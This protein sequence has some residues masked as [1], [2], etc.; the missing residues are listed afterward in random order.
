MQLLRLRRVAEAAL[1]R[2]SLPA[3][4]LRFVT[5]GENTTFRLD[6]GQ[7]RFLV[8]VHRP[9]RHGRDVHAETAIASEMAWLKA[10]RAETDL[11]VPTA[12]VASDGRVVV[13]AEAGGE[14]RLV[15]VLGWLSGRIHED[16]SRPTHFRRLGAALAVLHRQADGW[17][18]PPGFVRIRWDHE[19]F[20]GDVMTYGNLPALECRRLVPP[21][22]RRRF[23]RI[24]A[25]MEGVMAA[26]PDVGLIHADP[27]LGNA[28]FEGDRV[29][30]IDFDDCGTG[31]R[32]YDVAVAVWELRD[33]PQYVACR[34]ALLAGYTAV[35]PIDTAHLDD[36][37]ALRQVGFDLWYTGT[38]QLDPRFAARL[39]AV[40]RWSAD[41]LDV[42]DAA[43]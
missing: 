10:I 4:T 7:G 19:A 42:I 20:F 2:F 16:S 14:S 28:V 5:H 18:P 36:Y 1:R 27:H 6:G 11:E 22:L 37:I 40:H 23:D 8:R 24:G 30:L 39:D 31:P 34:D 33:E 43:R 3:G 32:L 35:R 38:A 9:A 25:R 26:D 15:S 17:R 21:A 29:K 12:V 41:M 13:R